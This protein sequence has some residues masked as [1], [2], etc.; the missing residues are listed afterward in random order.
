[1]CRDKSSHTKNMFRE[2]QAEYYLGI[3]E[4]ILLKVNTIS[5]LWNII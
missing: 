1:M 5:N 4:Y 3:E 2:S